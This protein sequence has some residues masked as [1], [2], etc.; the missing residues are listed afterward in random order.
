M[1]I[2]EEVRKIPNQA[3]AERFYNYPFLAIEESLANAVY[4]KNYQKREPIEVRIYP[5]RIEIQSFPGPLPPV[6]IEELN[7]GQ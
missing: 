5:D 2:R 6:T 4:H 3:E 7:K 1:Y